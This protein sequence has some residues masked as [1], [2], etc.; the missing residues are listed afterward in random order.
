MSYCI[1]LVEDEENLNQVLSHYISEEGW[2]VQSFT[3]GMEAQKKI[4]TPPD[5]WVLDIMIPDL[6][7]IQLIKAIKA[8]TPEIP[9]IFISARNS[10]IDRIMG[11]EL[12]SD[13]YL[14]KPFLPR[15]LIIRIQKILQRTY[16]DAPKTY[17][18]IIQ[19]DGYQVD[20]S[21]RTVC[22]KDES[23]ELTS[24]EF[25]LLLLLIENQN[26]AL[27]RNHILDQIW[28]TEAFYSD[29]V[30]DN[31]IKRLRKKMPDLRIETIYGFGYRRL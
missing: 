6:D 25:D 3:R 9:V 28:G 17:H 24:K 5:L 11:L 27:S 21:R 23:I 18:D 8:E 16:S 14:A 2:Q 1:Y 7:G 4:M 29:R 20:Q 15:E 30:V 13:D 19:V 26:K 12:G 22:K 10:D 31:L